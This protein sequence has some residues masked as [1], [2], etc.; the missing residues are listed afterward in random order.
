MTR[1]E[2]LLNTATFVTTLCSLLVVSIVVY[3]QFT[4]SPMPPQV[5]HKNRPVANWRTQLSLGRRIGPSTASVTVLEYADFQCP[6]C[7]GF[8][9]EIEKARV[10]HPKDISI[11]FRHFPLTGC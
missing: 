2:V 5:D 3:R 4:P 8:F 1:K 9:R 10:D 6:A 7:A 11:V